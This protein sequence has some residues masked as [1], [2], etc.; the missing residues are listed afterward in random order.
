MPPL[1]CELI[2]LV[3]GD[4]LCYSLEFFKRDSFKRIS[5]IEK[6]SMTRRND[7]DMLINCCTGNAIMTSHICNPYFRIVQKR[8]NFANLLIIKLRFTP[9]GPLPSACCCK[10][11]LHS[12]TNQTMFKFSQCRKHTK[13]QLPCRA[14]RLDFSVKLSKLTPRCSRSVTICTKSGKLRPSRSSRQ[15]TR[16]AP[17]LRDF[18]HCSSSGRAALLL[19]AA[20][21][22][23]TRP[24]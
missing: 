11:C 1:N 5:Y 17:S 8:L 24:A 16:V 13:N 18:L 9:S 6:S 2:N 7:S 4:V 12:F 19:L 15:T 10:P 3:S 21:S 23:R 14:A 22:H 20:R